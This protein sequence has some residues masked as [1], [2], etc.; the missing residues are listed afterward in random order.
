MRCIMPSMTLLFCAVTFA[1]ER[2]ELSVPTAGE[3]D[4][5][6]RVTAYV[7]GNQAPAKGFFPPVLEIHNPS[8]TTVK[9]HTSPLGF[10]AKAFEPMRTP[11]KQPGK[12]THEIFIQV[13]VQQVE[14]VTPPDVEMIPTGLQ[15]FS[16]LEIAP[17]ATTLVELLVPNFMFTGTRC[18][19]FCRLSGDGAEAFSVPVLV[20]AAKRQNWN[21][22]H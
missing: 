22:L 2:P 16:S 20:E 13:F 10:E 6:F 14:P 11:V 21:P 15:P 18:K 9:L 17:G 3:S 8:S 12:P 4:A 19:L 1:G 7:A 5:L